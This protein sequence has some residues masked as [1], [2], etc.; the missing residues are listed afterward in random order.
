M[1]Q[2]HLF[3]LSSKREKYDKYQNLLKTDSHESFVPGKYQNAN[4][5]YNQLINNLTELFDAR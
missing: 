5:Y 1:V 2:Q 3:K 4:E